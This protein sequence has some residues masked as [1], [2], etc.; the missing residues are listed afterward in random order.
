MRSTAKKLGVDGI[1]SLAHSIRVYHVCV[2][3][4]VNTYDLADDLNLAVWA[5]PKRRVVVFLHHSPSYSSMYLSPFVRKSI[6]NG[7]S[8][9]IDS[10]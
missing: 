7:Y 10:L 8:S 5:D 1:Q 6:N 4:S 9:E 2:C 3:V